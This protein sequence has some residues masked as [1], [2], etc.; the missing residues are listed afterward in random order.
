MEHFFLRYTASEGQKDLLQMVRKQITTSK[1]PCPF[2]M[3]SSP[4][5]QKADH[6]SLGSLCRLYDNWMADG[7]KLK[8][9]KKYPNV[10]YPLLLTGDK[11]K[12]ILKHVNILGLHLLLGAIDK[13]LKWIEKF[14]FENKEC[15]LQFVKRYLSKINTC[16]VS[17]Q[18]QHRLV[19]LRKYLQ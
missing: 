3:T 4:N 11:N 14:I 2:C 1:H 19:G 8:K 18:G 12:N 16:R 10:I 5:F 17:N 9:L 7:A 6:Y 13:I 15:G